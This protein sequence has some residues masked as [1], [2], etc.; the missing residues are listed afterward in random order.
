MAEKKYSADGSCLE[1]RLRELLQGASVRPGTDIPERVDRAVLAMAEAKAAQIRHAA[2]RRRTSRFLRRAVA[3][4][5]SIVLVTGIISVVSRRRE[6]SGGRMVAEFPVRESAKTVDIVDAYMLARALASGERPSSE[7]DH[8]R[9]GRVDAADVNHVARMA[10]SL[11]AKP[12]G[13]ESQDA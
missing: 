13:K 7:H 2:W 4:A 5:A 8:N 10:V 3:L 11:G 1:Q 12:V 6:D 9:D